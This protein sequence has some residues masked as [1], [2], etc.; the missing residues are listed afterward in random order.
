MGLAVAC[1]S[2]AWAT[3]HGSAR[4]FS[5]PLVKSPMNAS[6]VP[7]F[8]RPTFEGGTEG[9]W[10]TGSP[11]DGYACDACHTSRPTLNPKLLPPNAPARGAPLPSG[12]LRVEGLP[13]EGYVPGKRYEVR[14]SWPDFAARARAQY[15]AGQPSAY[16]GIVAELVAESGQDA[17]SIEALGYERLSPAEA[18]VFPPFPLATRLYRQP[19][20]PYIDSRGNPVIADRPQ[21]STCEMKEGVRCVIAV[22]SCGAEQ[23]RF[24]WT[25]PEEFQGPIWF[26]AGYVSTDH[27]TSDPAEDSVTLVSFPM[28]PAA[29]PDYSSTLSASS[30]SVGTG[31]AS[32]SGVPWLAFLLTMWIWRRRRAESLQS[33]GAA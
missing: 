28:A 33:R 15:Q 23:S 26:S 30:C 2:V 5:E 17:G 19:V 24:L 9:R 8:S 20:T 6:S 31:R 12:P 1:L 25:A 3:L 10:F 4:A 27:R 22:A 16:M 11:A 21:T 7:Y 29:A 14:L 18:C 13:K 32:S